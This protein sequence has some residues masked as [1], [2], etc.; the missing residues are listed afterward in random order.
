MGLQT[1]QSDVL[2]DCV[3]HFSCVS[4][5]A[6]ETLERWRKVKGVPRRPRSPSIELGPKEFNLPILLS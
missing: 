5:R 6:S 4:P 2:V 1:G 3:K